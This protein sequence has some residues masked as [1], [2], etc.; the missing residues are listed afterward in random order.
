[1]SEKIRKL[2]AEETEKVTGGKIEKGADGGYVVGD[3]PDATGNFKTLEEA[4]FHARRK[5]VCPY[6][7]KVF[8]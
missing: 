7:G 3:D 5:G 4:K 2:T 1:M 8:S 6:C